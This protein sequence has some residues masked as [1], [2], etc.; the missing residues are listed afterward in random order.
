MWKTVITQAGFF[1]KKR[2][3]IYAGYDDQFGAGKWRVAW[4]IPTDASSVITDMAGVMALYEDAYFAHLQ[5]NPELLAE[6][7]A[8]ASNVYDDASSNV[9]SG[10]DYTIQETNL[11]HLHDIAIR[12]SVLRLGTWFHGEELIQIRGSKSQHPLSKELSPGVVPFHL[13]RLIRK[14]EVI[15]WWKEGSIEAFYQSGKIV[16]QWTEE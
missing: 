3:D 10:F 5:S 2:A 6:L 13:S 16:Q 7:T 9:G 1:G 14:P 15:G 11:N 4:E 8:A 12:R